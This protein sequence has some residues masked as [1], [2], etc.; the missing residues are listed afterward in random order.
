MCGGRDY[1]YRT[2]VYVAL[3]E[4]H[5]KRGIT[6]VIHGDAGKTDPDTGI[7]LCGA[8]RLAGEWARLFGIPVEPY[9]ADWEK[10]GKKAGAIRNTEMLERSKPDGGVAFPGG[11]G[12][13][14]MVRKMKKAGLR[15]WEPPMPQQRG[16]V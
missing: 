7:V 1:A 6:C 3:G 2:H 11:T 14:D 13:A 15:V 8:D 10:H 9:P 4:L 16:E 5:R 12:T